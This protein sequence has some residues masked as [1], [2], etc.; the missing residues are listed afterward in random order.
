MKCEKFKHSA[1]NQLIGYKKHY[2]PAHYDLGESRLHDFQPEAEKPEGQHKHAKV[3]NSNI[4]S[5][6]HNHRLI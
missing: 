3:Q 1:I 2:L 6:L 4:F 5:P